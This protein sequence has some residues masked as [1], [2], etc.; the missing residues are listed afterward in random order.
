M[1]CGA[2]TP[3]ANYM[4]TRRHNFTPKRPGGLDAYSPFSES[5]CVR[6]RGGGV[7]RQ[8]MVVVVLDKEF[9][10]LTTSQ[11]RTR[12]KLETMQGGQLP[13]RGT[14]N[15]IPFSSLSSLLIVVD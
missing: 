7:D 2:Q 3:K 4:I 6:H 8:I 5:C 10:I 15:N 13:T 11:S 14:G 1:F 9:V 12:L